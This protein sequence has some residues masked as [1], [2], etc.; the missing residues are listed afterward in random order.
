[1]NGPHDHPDALS[2]KYRFKQFLL[3]REFILVNDETNCS[4]MGEDLNPLPSE[5]V[6]S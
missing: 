2:C 6:L 3:G 4:S 5:M 1:M